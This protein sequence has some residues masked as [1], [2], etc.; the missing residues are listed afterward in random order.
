[1]NSEPALWPHRLALLLCCATFPLVW[2][3]GMVTTY[4]AGMAV[5]D[6][7]TT[8]GYNLFL[9]PWK[10]WIF[11][12]WDLF[13]EHGHR[14]FASAV[15]ML[16]IALCVLLWKTAQPRWLLMLGFV[17]LAAVIFQGV[18]GG[19]RVVL[20]ERT[21]AMLHGCTGPAFFAFTAALAAVSSRRW[22]ENSNSA[23]GDAS[24]GLLFMTVATPVLA[25]L[26]IILG[27]QVRHIAPD[28]APQT[29]QILVFFH[30]AVGLALLAQI[31]AAAVAVWRSRIAAS[32][33]IRLALILCGLVAVQVV[34]GC[35]TWIVKYGWPAFL[36]NSDNSVAFTV[37]AQSWWQAQITTAHVA[38]GSLIFALST[39]QAVFCVHQMWPQFRKLRSAGVAATESPRQMNFD[40]RLTGKSLA[41]AAG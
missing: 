26:Q 32:V 18:L 13:I 16:T 10:T 2:I 28:A 30:V 33:N 29:F 25:Y 17:A 11:G 35:G 8:Y 27:A 4:K 38:V 6:W 21:L 3:G 14:L 37:Q 22:R 40:R 12:P 31:I 7:P 15:G 34:L 1:L 24:P 39:V 5:P 19:L 9:Y 23:T 36:F 41:E 20:N